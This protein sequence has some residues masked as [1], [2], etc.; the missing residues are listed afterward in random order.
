MNERRSQTATPVRPTPSSVWISTFTA[1]R[2]GER[3][4]PDLSLNAARRELSELRLHGTIFAG[5]ELPSWAQINGGA[6][7]WY[8]LIADLIFPLVEVRG[9]WSTATCVESPRLSGDRTPYGTPA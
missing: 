4:R 2:Y 6:N 7:Q 9:G 1:E 3:V 8:L 5:D